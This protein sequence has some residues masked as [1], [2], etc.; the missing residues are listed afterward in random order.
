MCKKGKNKGTHLE[1]R[2]DVKNDKFKVQKK[3]QES[4]VGNK[5]QVQILK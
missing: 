2:C 3:K 5:T 1:V 4:K